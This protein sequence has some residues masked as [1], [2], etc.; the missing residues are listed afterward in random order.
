MHRLN[1]HNYREKIIL[2]KQYRAYLFI[3]V[4]IVI[5]LV[6]NLIFL[7]FLEISILKQ[8]NVNKVFKDSLNKLD[9]QMAPAYDFQNKLNIAKE[10]LEFIKTLEKNKTEMVE[11]IQYLDKSV[12]SQIYFTNLEISKKD[13][14][15]NFKGIALNPLYIAQFIDSLRESNGVFQKPLLQANSVLDDG[16]YAFEMS[17]SIHNKTLKPEYESE[18]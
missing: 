3:S 6:M 10:K 1:L 13:S 14:S 18:Y 5:P 4:A 12:P 9:V 8:I 11:I 15:V 17:A 7:C 2:Y 16:S